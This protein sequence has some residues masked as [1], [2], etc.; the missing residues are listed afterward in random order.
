LTHIATYLTL[1][2]VLREDQSALLELARHRHDEY[3]ACPHGQSLPDELASLLAQYDEASAIRCYEP[4]SIPPLLQTADYAELRLRHRFGT[5][6]DSNAKVRAR[7]RR[8]R[9]LY[10]RVR[11]ECTFYLHEVTLRSLPGDAELQSGQ[12][13]FLA[14][15]IGQGHCRIRVVPAAPEHTDLATT[16]FQLIKLGQF[17]SLVCVHADA[18]TLFMEAKAVVA[19]YEALVDRLDQFALSDK[20]SADLI[21]RLDSERF[22]PQPVLLTAGAAR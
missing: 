21:V 14:M 8:Q 3:W 18:A 22:Q 10:D 4:A 11:P 20:D 6:I 7:M 17:Q 19:T 13:A 5:A 1:C 15:L 12:L 2:G 16:G 9:D